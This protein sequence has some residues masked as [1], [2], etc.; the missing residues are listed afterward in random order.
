MYTLAVLRSKTKLKKRISV[1]SFIEFFPLLVASEW[2]VGMWRFYQTIPSI[3]SYRFSIAVCCHYE[4]CFE[5][6][7]NYH[8]AIFFQT[9]QNCRCQFLVDISSVFT[10][11]GF[12]KMKLF[13]FC[14]K[15][16]LFKKRWHTL[17]T[18][19]SK[20]DFLWFIFVEYMPAIQGLLVSLR[21]IFGAKPLLGSPKSLKKYWET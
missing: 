19:K 7:W 21:Q 3:G 8:C 13:K 15:N 16:Y 10:V 5:V 6:V 9:K 18:R 14:N 4:K 11:I 1:K 2:L 20:F 17:G 12:N